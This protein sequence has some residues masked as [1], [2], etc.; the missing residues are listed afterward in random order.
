MCAP[1]A[2]TNLAGG[3]FGEPQSP[4]V[5]QRVLD[6]EVVFVV[7]HGHGLGIGGGGITR[8]RRVVSTLWRDGNCGQIDLLRHVET[9]G[10]GSK[11]TV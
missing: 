10:R 7:E 4:V 3:G 8:A 6:V 2:V 11:G 1:K 9:S 5:G